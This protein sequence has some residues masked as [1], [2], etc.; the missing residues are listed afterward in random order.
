VKVPAGGKLVVDYSK[1]SKSSP[2]RAWVQ[3]ASGQR[4]S[5]TLEAVTEQLIDT[6]RDQLY[7]VVGPN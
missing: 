1:V 7:E 2:P 5:V 6:Y 3:S 4:T